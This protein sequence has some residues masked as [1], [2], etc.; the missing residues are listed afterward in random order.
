MFSKGRNGH[1]TKQVL[2]KGKSFFHGEG[3]PPVYTLK[4]M[5][6]GGFPLT[7]VRIACLIMDKQDRETERK[8]KFEKT[9]EEAWKKA[10]QIYLKESGLDED[11]HEW[12]AILTTHSSQEVIDILN[13]TWEKRKSHP[14]DDSQFVGSSMPKSKT[15]GFKA[16]I[17][18]VSN[19]VI[20]RK[21]SGHI[22]RQPAAD[23]NDASQSDIDKRTDLKQKLSGKPPKGKGL[24]DAGEEGINTILSVTKSD[25]LK[26]IVDQVEKFSGVLQDLASLSQVVILPFFCV[27]Y[28]KVAPYAPI[29][30]GCIRMFFKV[31]LLISRLTADA[32][33]G[34]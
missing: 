14:E 4:L 6:P 12:K 9:M 19:P 11:S 7:V 20:G 18:R 31:T 33:L 29:A 2:Q 32:R 1:L 3:Q 26:T 30:L 23:T 24:V 17:K 13:E 22:L 34:S 8:A 21:E 27:S 28:G 16:S 10:C 25:A 15:K 5:T